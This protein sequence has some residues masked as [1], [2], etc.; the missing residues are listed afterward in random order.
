MIK[1]YIYQGDFWMISSFEIILKIY[2]LMYMLFNCRFV[3][4]V[5][6]IFGICISNGK[7][8]VCIYLFFK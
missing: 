3:M 2:V 6:F 1:Y 5:D 7:R 4:N 8:Y